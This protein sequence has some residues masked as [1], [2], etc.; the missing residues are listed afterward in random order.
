MDNNAFLTQAEAADVLRMSPRTLERYRV[1]G[2]GPR[3]IK[4]GRRVL[5]KFAELEAWADA[6]TFTSTSEEGQRRG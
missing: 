5:Y 3:Y 6:N 4:A 2:N 1:A